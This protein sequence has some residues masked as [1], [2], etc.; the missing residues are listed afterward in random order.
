MIGSQNGLLLRLILLFQHQHRNRLRI[1]KAV[2]LVNPTRMRSYEFG[3]IPRI[4]SASVL[5]R[6]YRWFN[7]F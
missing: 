3:I 1:S 4:L 7:D 2:H 5:V 6:A